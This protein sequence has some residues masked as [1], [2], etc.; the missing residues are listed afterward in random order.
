MKLT[1]GHGTE[2]DFLLYADDTVRFD[3]H[4]IAAVCDRRTGIG[5]DGVIRAATIGSVDTPTARVA[6]EAGAQWYMDYRNAD[7]SPAEM[8]GNGVRVFAH[9]LRETG[10]QMTEK[11]IIGTAVGPVMV[12]TTSSPFATDSSTGGNSENGMDCNVEGADSATWYRVRLPRGPKP[13][14]DDAF[15]AVANLRPPRPA[16]SVDMENPHT[17]V[18]VAQAAELEALD[19]RKP[20]E[21]QPVPPDGTN[22]EF[23]VIDHGPL[24]EVTNPRLQN[25]G[26]LSM[27]VYERGVGETRACGTGACAAALAASHWAGKAAPRE[28]FVT[29]PGGTVLVEVEDDVA[30]LSGPAVL[31]AEAALL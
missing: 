21:V 26:R 31:T 3:P 24:P 20:P 30:I 22:V 12:E 17:V 18:A 14:A 9:F 29:Q 6:E 23:I 27:R 1:K 16:A 15:A 25:A 4:A 8:C 5:A 10:L 13:I 28:W 11:L 7:G 19:L 2:N